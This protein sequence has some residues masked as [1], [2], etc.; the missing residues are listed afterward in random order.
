M[1]RRDRNRMNRITLFLASW[2]PDSL[3]FF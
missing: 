1:G 3:R 2:F